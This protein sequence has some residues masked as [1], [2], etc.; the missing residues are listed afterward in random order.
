MGKM[1][2]FIRA[3]REKR[4]VKVKVDTYEKG[5]IERRCIPFDYGP[6]SRGKD[7]SDKYHLF[8]LDSPSD[9]HVLSIFPVQLLSIEIENENFDPGDYINW[10]TNWHVERD[11][12]KYS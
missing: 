6:P 3:I 8:T 11:W 4:I 10:E 12:G 1:Q 5:I 2:K 9:K 7:K